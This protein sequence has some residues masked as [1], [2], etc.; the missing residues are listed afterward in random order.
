MEA[1]SWI[2]G[3][4]GLRRTHLK[5]IQLFYDKEGQLLSELNDTIEPN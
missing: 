3:L 1:D 4:L 2:D 5:E